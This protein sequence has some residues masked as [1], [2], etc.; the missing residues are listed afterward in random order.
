MMASLGPDLREL[1]DGDAVD[2]VTRGQHHVDGLGEPLPVGDRVRFGVGVVPR[3]HHEDDLGMVQGDG[4][5][6]VRL[7][8]GVVEEAPSVDGMLAHR[9]IAGRL[10]GRLDAGLT[11]VHDTVADGHD[12][13]GI[14]GG[15]DP[16]GGEGDRRRQE[17]GDRGGRDDPDHR[18]PAPDGRRCRR[19]CRAEEEGGH[20]HPRRRHHDAAGTSIPSTGGA[21]TDARADRSWPWRRPRVAASRAVMSAAP[22]SPVVTSVIST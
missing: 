3:P 8:V 16:P 20:G 2:A 22:S 4:G 1:D 18:G 10:H 14:R 12:P 5:G 21:G 7:E 13:Q 15:Q 6:Q 9:H 11:V 19:R 17:V